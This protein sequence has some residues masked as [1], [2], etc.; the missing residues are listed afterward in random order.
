M[1]YGESGPRSCRSRRQRLAKSLHFVIARQLSRRACSVSLGQ[2]PITSN[3]T[4]Q[5]YENT[6]H[7]RH[8]RAQPHPQQLQRHLPVHQE[9]CLSRRL[10][11]TLLRQENG[12]LQN[13][14]ALNHR[15]STLAARSSTL[16]A[17]SCRCADLAGASACLDGYA[18]HCKF[19][20]GAS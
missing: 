1:A 2:L 11:Q 6:I 12:R 7:T 15:T 14:L 17:F 16:R 18:Q 4:L 19:T 3:N 5:Q 10:H 8:R 13:L 9:N 20:S